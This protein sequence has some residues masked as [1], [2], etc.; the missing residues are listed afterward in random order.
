MSGMRLRCCVVALTLGVA[1]WMG[2][3]Q[4]IAQSSDAQAQRLVVQAHDFATQGKLQQAA[5][6][7]QAALEGLPD[8]KHPRG[9]SKVDVLMQLSRLH[10]GLGNPQTARIAA[11]RAIVLCG[12]QVG[13]CPDLQLAHLHAD[14]ANAEMRL[15]DLSAARAHF[16][17]SDELAI[18]AKV[19]GQRLRGIVNNQLG[20][21]YLGQANCI[22]AIE[23]FQRSLAALQGLGLAQS[24]EASFPRLGL[25]Q[26]ELNLSRLHEAEQ[27]VGRA[28]AILDRPLDVPGAVL[29][30]QRMRALSQWG[31]VLRAVG[32]L[33]DA[34]VRLRQGQR[35][36][37]DAGSG[38]VAALSPEIGSV[39]VALSNN[40]ALALLQRGGEGDEAEAEKAVRHAL[41][42]ALQVG[43]RGAGNA[44]HSSMVA[45]TR[46]NLG[47]VLMRRKKL[48]EAARELES[49]ETTLEALTPPGDI[50]LG[51]ALDNLST[52]E[53]ARGNFQ[54]ALHW[55]QRAKQNEDDAM[56]LALSAGDEEHKLLFLR[57]QAPTMSRATSIALAAK[58]SEAVG[59]AFDKVLNRRG[60]V[61]E[62][63]TTTLAEAC[64][65]NAAAEARARCDAYRNA[66]LG[67]AD[68]LARANASGEEPGR[69][70]R[71]ASARALFRQRQAELPASSRLAKSNLTW[72]QVQ[73]H[74][75]AQGVLIE[76][77]VY[78]PFL[79]MSG[80]MWGEDT[81]AAFVLG[82]QGEPKLI[83]LAASSEV[84][85]LVRS[86]R[87]ALQSPQ[88]TAITSDGCKAATSDQARPARRLDAVVFEPLRKAA[89]TATD[90]FV[91]P[92]GSL[93]V[94]PFAA[95]QD[96]A[97]QHLISTPAR[98]S[99]LGSGRE[100]VRGPADRALTRSPMTI[101]AD[102]DF[103]D[104]AQAATPTWQ[105]RKLLGLELDA[106]GGIAR[107]KDSAL[108]A[109][110]VAGL[111]PGARVIEGSAANKQAMRDLRSPWMLVV[112]THGIFRADGLDGVGVDS[113]RQ[114]QPA[115]GVRTLLESEHPLL[116]SAVVLAGANLL[117]QPRGDDGL[118]TALEASALQ[119]S[120]TELV[121]LSAC[122]TGE[123]EQIAAEGLYGL[124]RG[125]AIA[126]AESQLV[127]LW[128]VNSVVTRDL[129]VDFFK[130]L[131]A[132]QSRSQALKAAQAK[133][134][135]AS[136]N[137]HPFYWAAFVLLGR[138]G[139]LDARQ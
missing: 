118:L 82:K 35:L 105:P 111:F 90:F 92:E 50:R 4:A 126:G 103:G 83:P 97:C 99:Y 84:D 30:L 122:H 47:F 25:A 42:L 59:S 65:A 36:M 95:L 8:L 130:G 12:T 73:Q 68:D 75:P 31:E 77:V 58:S 23:R 52:L 91:V 26:C 46:R 93:R 104:M 125:F 119:L 87:R 55:E 76:Y 22:V 85:R 3:A 54:R 1:V 88:D 34:V 15:N 63:L 101:M 128:R 39:L 127:S 106:T 49:A 53:L 134:S 11:E 137:S 18:H 121:V 51:A 94:I 120:G 5:E 132:G 116:R 66:V 100:L 37:G 19:I 61:Q 80:R 32:R 41:D 29:L 56:Q 62:L 79:S 72:Q 78:R 13:A 14:M 9:A 113:G 133:V 110:R 21:L 45:D 40:E 44:E 27:N 74:L 33:D 108:E 20:W 86:V 17:R 16:L 71:L 114:L 96:E 6:A 24:F 67:Y 10:L 109:A 139:P 102:P 115:P 135:Q 131:K 117:Y 70:R 98:L 138:A 43:Q 64:R 48:D 38:T 123:G 2:A 136:R 81:F 57:G 28:W 69:E 129:V 107:L 89:G 7:Y 60:R 124:Q 112:S